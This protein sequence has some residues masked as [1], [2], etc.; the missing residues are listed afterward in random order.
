MRL[1]SEKQALIARL[2]PPKVSAVSVVSTT[3]A[4]PSTDGQRANEEKAIASAE[5]AALDNALREAARAEDLKVKLSQR[6]EE[7]RDSAAARGLLRRELDGVRADTSDTIRAM[8]RQ[9]EDTEEA[10]RDETKRLQGELDR[11]HA[12][13]MAA[14]DAGRDKGRQMLYI[15]SLR[16]RPPRSNDEASLARAL[17][18]TKLTWRDGKYL[19]DFSSDMLANM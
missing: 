1:Y 4:T 19:D 16:P 13:L 17:A 8:K 3:P 6:E 12:L 14:L 18:R 7:L 11:M 5:K 10:C 2:L 15:E 9:M